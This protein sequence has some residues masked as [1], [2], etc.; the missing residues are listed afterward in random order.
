LSLAEIQ[1]LHSSLQQIS[2]ILGK[3]DRQVDTVHE[4][5]PRTITE[6][7]EIEYIFYRV[8]SILQ[9]MGL[10]PQIDQA[11]NQIQKLIM[12]IR[13]LTSLMRFIQMFSVYGGIMA[14]LSAFGM[15]LTMQDMSLE[16][17]SR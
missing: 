2:D 14:F 5:T 3:I 17:Q 13:M 4:K 11:I 12:I 15:A 1:A 6:V 16:A 7:R 9:R 10:P 8:S